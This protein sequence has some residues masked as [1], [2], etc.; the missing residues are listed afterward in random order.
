MNNDTPIGGKPP[1]K[2][3][4]NRWLIVPITR[5]YIVVLCSPITSNWSDPRAGQCSYNS[6]KLIIALSI[7][8]LRQPF[9]P[10][11]DQLQIGQ[12]NCL[13]LIFNIDFVLVKSL[14]VFPFC[15]IR[16][17]RSFLETLLRA[18]FFFL[19]RI[20]FVYFLPFVFLSLWCAM[21]AW[22]QMWQVSKTTATIWFCWNEKYCSSD[23]IFVSHSFNVDVRPCVFIWD[24]NYC[25]IISQASQSAQWH[26]SLTLSALV[27]FNYVWNYCCHSCH[28][29]FLIRRSFFISS[30]TYITSNLVAAIVHII[31][32]ISMWG[33]STKC[34]QRTHRYL[35]LSCDWYR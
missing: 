17:R 35:L 26:R 20:Q 28:S 18:F 33:T 9:S 5:N 29:N 23:L 13:R 27:S 2:V 21:F 22:C 3:S 11:F 24:I 25:F 31:F 1:E 8:F 4:Q 15:V 34:A 12:L 32:L 7:F 10:I 6:P 30:T 19:V 16:L 14:R